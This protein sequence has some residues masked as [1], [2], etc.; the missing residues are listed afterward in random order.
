MSIE[1]WTANGKKSVLISDCLAVTTKGSD[2][3]AICAGGL[4]GEI[5]LDSISIIF[6]QLPTI[7]DE[8]A[9][10][11]RETREKLRGLFRDKH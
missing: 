11:L 9:L 6:E 1:I 5:N 3:Y 7:I 4:N 10:E 2:F 8:K